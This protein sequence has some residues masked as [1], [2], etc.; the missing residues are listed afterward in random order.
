MTYEILIPEKIEKI[1]DTR[2]NKDLKKRLYKKMQK[3]KEMPQNY[4]KPLRHPLAGIWELYFEKSW[5][6]LF[7]IN[8]E[9]KVV[10]VVGFKHKDE[11]INLIL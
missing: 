5:R 4:A 1:L 7:E 9:E 3:L 10:S 6:I 11:M 8:D 2:L